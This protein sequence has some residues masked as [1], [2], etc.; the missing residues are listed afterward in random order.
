MDDVHVPPISRRRMLKRVGVGTA[1]AWSAPVLSSIRVPAYAQSPACDPIGQFCGPPDP[2]CGAPGVACPLPPEC[3]VGACNIT[4][5][6]RCVCWI[7]AYCTSP[8]PVCQSDADC[9]PGEFCVPVDPACEFLCAG[10]R[11][12]MHPCN[13]SGSAPQRA[14]IKVTRA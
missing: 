10:N 7:F 6:G 2:R 1:I 3:Q 13:L 9:A 12:C 14:G 4:L 5:G 11:A 8:N